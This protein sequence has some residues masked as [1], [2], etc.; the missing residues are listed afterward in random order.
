[1][2]ETGNPMVSASAMFLD[3]P[4]QEGPATEHLGSFLSQVLGMGER[5]C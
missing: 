2:R 4:S 3:Q 1:M 5:P